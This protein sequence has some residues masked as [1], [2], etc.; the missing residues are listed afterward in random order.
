MRYNEFILEWSRLL[1]MKTATD[2]H[3]RICECDIRQTSFSKV[4][5]SPQK[6]MP[7]KMSPTLGDETSGSLKHDHSLKSQKF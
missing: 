1:Q 7:L 5:M 4:E 2:L 3:T 6:D